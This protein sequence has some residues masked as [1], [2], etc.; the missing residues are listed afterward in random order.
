MRSLNLAAFASPLGDIARERS[1]VDIRSDLLRSREALNPYTVVAQQVVAAL[2]HWFVFPWL[3]P[4]VIN[5]L[6]HAWGQP[7]HTRSEGVKESLYVQREDAHGKF[8]RVRLAAPIGMDEPLEE[9]L[10]VVGT[11]FPFFASLD[12]LTTRPGIR[13]YHVFDHSS[14]ERFLTCIVA[15]MSV[16]RPLEKEE[17][18]LHAS[19]SVGMHAERGDVVYLPS[20]PYAKIGMVVEPVRCD[21]LARLYTPEGIHH[22]LIGTDGKDLARRERNRHYPL[23]DDEFEE[24]VNKLKV[25]WAAEPSV[26]QR[27]PLG[28]AAAW[29]GIH[30]PSGEYQQLGYVSIQGWD[31]ACGRVVGYSPRD[32]RFAW[33]AISSLPIPESSMVRLGQ[34]REGED[35][36]ALNQRFVSDDVRIMTTVQSIIDGIV[37][38]RNVKA[39][40]YLGDLRRYS[41]LLD[42]LR[43]CPQVPAQLVAPQFLSLLTSYGQDGLEHLAR[44]FDQDPVALACDLLREDVKGAQ[45]VL[46]SQR[47]VFGGLLGELEDLVHRETRYSSLAELLRTHASQAHVYQVP[48]DGAWTLARI[49]G[50]ELL[51]TDGELD[52]DGIERALAEPTATSDLS[53]ATSR[54][55]VEVATHWLQGWRSPL[56]AEERSTPFLSLEQLPNPFAMTDKEA[57]ALVGVHYRLL[58]KYRP[59][60]YGRDERFHLS[61]PGAQEINEHWHPS[62]LSSYGEFEFYN[63]LFERLEHVGA[64]G[65]E[66]F[67]EK[68]QGLFSRYNRTYHKKTNK[69]LENREYVSPSDLDTDLVRG[70]RS[71]EQGVRSLT[72]DLALHARIIDSLFANEPL[73]REAYHDYVAL[74]KLMMVRDCFFDKDERIKNSYL[75][76]FGVVGDVRDR[77]RE[78]FYP[79]L[80]SLDP[81]HRG[82]SPYDNDT[83]I[84][85]MAR[86]YGYESEGMSAFGYRPNQLLE[87]ALGRLEQR[88]VESRRRIARQPIAGLL[89]QAE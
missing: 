1:F 52:A 42:E 73:L 86:E 46:S 40:M 38:D 24:R 10:C 29:F 48:R 37:N 60:R 4:A 3:Q 12:A 88:V 61:A 65:I 39:V 71:V 22:P 83:S 72:R 25:S 69:E 89:S 56:H 75:A 62:A 7:F 84:V 6:V 66:S 77:W 44:L 68:A 79:A 26:Q 34:L 2:S 47:M 23:K 45:E 78:D 80:T 15:D 5:P 81:F 64:A 17:L 49:E 28:S 87:H 8:Q 35:L 58:T 36:L 54:L 9:R 32:E 11:G 57:H 33:G 55:S 67:L 18:E 59:V 14:L 19:E 82:H 41:V 30:A 43:A 74:Q 76:L 31:A 70:I 53:T 20:Q 50:Y 85:T 21:Y 16:L 27:L 63:E 51:T 13:E